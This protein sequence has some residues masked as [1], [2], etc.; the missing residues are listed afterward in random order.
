MRWRQWA[1]VGLIV[2]SIAAMFLW[3]TQLREKLVF[4]RAAVCAAD[5]PAGEVFSKDMVKIVRITPES[6]VCGV[7]EADA[8]EYIGLKTAVPLRENQQLLPEYFSAEA[9]AAEGTASFVIDSSWICSQ[10]SLDEV[11]DTVSLR[12]VESGEYLGSYKISAL[13]GPKSS[14]ELCAGFEDYMLIRSAA[15]ENGPGSIIVINT[16]AR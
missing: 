15:E 16:K 4:R 7:E 5:I 14:L 3:E 13:P 2:L 11:G 9:P 8:A 12:L 10:S 6:A 1:G